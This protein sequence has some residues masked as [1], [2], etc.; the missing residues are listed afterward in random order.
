[1]PT[2]GNLRIN[3]LINTNIKSLLNEAKRLGDLCADTFPEIV[4]EEPR[5]SE[6]GDF[7]TTV[8]MTLAKHERKNPRVIADAIC[9]CLSN[10]KGLV[11]SAETAGPGFINLR[12]NPSFYLDCLMD[13]I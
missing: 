2:S 8:A 3:S 1:M 13:S 12:M 10:G 9:K 11:K 7:S 6:L 4:V 5:D